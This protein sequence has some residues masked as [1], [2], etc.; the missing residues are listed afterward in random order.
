MFRFVSVLAFA[1]VATVLPA[2]AA[3]RLALIIG[4]AAYKDVGELTNPH[5][6]ADAVAKA[7][8]AAGFDDV[9]HADDLS[10]E[11]MRKELKE[12]SGRAAG[13]EIAVVYYAGHGAEVADQN[14]L[15]PV[16]AKL[17]RS[18]D[19]E[20]E[21]IPLSSVR[22]AVSGASKL[23][24]VVLDACRNN[25]FKL[26][27][28]NGKRG[29]TR[30]LASIEPGAGEVVAYSAKEGTLAQ[31]GPSNS[32]SPFATA[33]VKSLKEPG[34]EIRLLF[35]RVRDDVLSATANEQEPYTYASLGGDAIYLQ[36]PVIGPS[37]LSAAAQEWQLIAAT[38]SANV[39]EAFRNKYRG[40]AVYSALAEER[41]ALLSPPVI[42]ATRT[43]IR[44]CPECPDMVE[45]PSGHFVMGSAEGE[46]G[47]EV[48]EGPQHAVV[49]GKSFAVG[50]FEITHGQFSAFLAETGYLQAPSCFLW[51][52]K[53]W[54]DRKG[55]GFANPG[56]AQT[57]NHPATCISWTD[58]N[59]Y[60]AWLSTKSGKKYRLLTESEWEYAAQHTGVPSPD[61]A[62]FESK[63]TT[64]IGRYAANSF[65]LHDMQGN[66]W[67]W[68]QD[69]YAKD[70][71]AAPTNGTAYITPNCQR[72]YRGGGWAN[73]AK[74][75]RSTARGHNL[76]NIHA[77][78]IGF[79]VARDL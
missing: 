58:A 15:I 71:T 41:L 17:L 10:A 69:C 30:G 61:M 57:D 74:D 51:N 42:A 6:D 40:D 44:D 78:V 2:E 38:N 56:F 65:G 3:K 16:D 7:F 28:S 9:R 13:S 39:L 4:N 22:S 49:I 11:Q 37:L 1:L 23:R 18:T 36:P 14:Y 67:E 66:V 47:H 55:Y 29:A 59:T 68:T 52:G 31:D 54:A 20:F 25:P 32:N 43:T 8:T 53:T 70:Y 19:I 26:A 48:E 76:A 77:D 35:G 79:R 62:N 46:A 27:G 60:I 12:F 24:M 50:K 45:I 64:Q 63:S 75:Q 73:P 72:T 33:L 21:A 34:L 5:A